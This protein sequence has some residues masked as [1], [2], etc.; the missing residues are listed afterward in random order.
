MNAVESG[1]DRGIGG[2]VGGVGEGC[3]TWC[4]ATYMS[5]RPSVC[6][7]VYAWSTTG[8]CALLYCTPP[9]WQRKVKIRVRQC[10]YST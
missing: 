9:R 6:L 7:P 3:E 5:V 4:N 10:S 1:M 2:G 8:R